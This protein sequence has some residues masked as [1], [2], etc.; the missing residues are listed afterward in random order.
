M[1]GIDCAGSQVGEVSRRRGYALLSLCAATGLSSVP[2]P[3]FA[4]IVVVNA[5]VTDSAAHPL[6]GAQL[7]L[8]QLPDRVIAR[9]T[10]NDAGHGTLS[11]QVDTGVIELFVRRLGYRSVSRFFAANARPA[12]TLLIELAPLQRT[13]A[14]VRVTAQ[15]D[16][17]HRRLYID[18]DAISSSPR[19]LE[20]A[21]DIVQKL[22]P[23]MIFG[24]G[25]R[26]GGCPAVR[27]IWVN[28][29]RIYPEFV[30]PDDAAHA[31]QGITVMRAVPDHVMAVLASIRSE[32]IAQMTYHDCRDMSVGSIG[33]ENAIFVVLKNGVKF[34]PGRGSYRISIDA[35]APSGP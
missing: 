20:D 21:A 10:T 28:G 14:T 26:S 33:S 31:R 5:T 35:G 25:G 8:I 12:D 34:E 7:V 27:D 9:T 19:R 23:D 3:A 30:P 6:A 11:T 1:R 17:R 16:L 18:A 2:R 15:E 13:L 4:Q 24:L 32:D 29:R 22:R